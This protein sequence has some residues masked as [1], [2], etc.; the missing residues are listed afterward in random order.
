MSQKTYMYDT[1]WTALINAIQ[2][3]DPTAIVTALGQIKTSIDAIETALG[4]LSADVTQ[5][6]TQWNDLL[7]AIGSG[8]GG[9]G[10]TIDIDATQWTNLLTSIDKGDT[11]ALATALGLIKTSIDSINTSL[12]SLSTDV[13]QN[14]TQ[15]TNLINAIT[16]Q[17]LTV[18]L[19]NITSSVVSNLSDASG[20]TLTDVINSNLTY[21]PVTWT[22]TSPRATIS[23][24]DCRYIKI[25]CLV[26]FFGSITFSATQSSQQALYLDLPSNMNIV[27]S[28]V[29]GGAAST[30]DH[31]F[32]LRTRAQAE[33]RL[34]L[35]DSGSI[36]YSTNTNIAGKTLL[37]SFTCIVSS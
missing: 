17:S 10:G 21:N 7:T 22:P 26:Y 15:W 8:G 30:S 35:Y 33:G 9:G 18:D 20:S 11:S 32:D 25:G 12:G 3:G 6:S 2:G 1:Q 27:N 24:S 5:D 37:V 36:V 19:S 31:H 14:S 23:S 28:S 34:Y 29:F 13:T 16:N 4:S